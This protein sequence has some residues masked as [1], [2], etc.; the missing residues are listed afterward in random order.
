MLTETNYFV[1]GGGGVCHIPPT[2]L[3]QPRGLLNMF[4][5]A[6][7]HVAKLQPPTRTPTCTG[8]ASGNEFCSRSNNCQ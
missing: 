3:Q 7:A 8:F 1:G 4:W 6:G 2:R 5:H